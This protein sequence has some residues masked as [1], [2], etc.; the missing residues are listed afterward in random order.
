MDLNHFYH[1][2]RSTNFAQ[3]VMKEKRWI[4]T[5]QMLEVLKNDADNEQEYTLSI[6]GVL[7]ATHWLVY[8]SKRET[9]GFSS[10]WYNYEWY[11][12]DEL[13]DIYKERWWR[14]DA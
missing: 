6:G 3:K 11:S 2:K 10:D 13:L 9:Y 1:K 12:E 14:R 5:E 8:D 7:F 4:K